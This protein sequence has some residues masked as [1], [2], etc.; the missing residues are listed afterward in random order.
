MNTSDIEKLNDIMKSDLSLDYFGKIIQNGSLCVNRY[1]LNSLKYENGIPILDIMKESLMRKALPFFIMEYFKVDDTNIEPFM[2]QYSDASFKF[3]HCEKVSEKIIKLDVD[4]DHYKDVII[5]YPEKI[6]KEIVRSYVQNSECV[7]SKLEDFNYWRYFKK[8]IRGVSE[9]DQ[10]RMK[11][12]T[13]PKIFFATN[14]SY[15]NVYEN[16]NV[17]KKYYNSKYISGMHNRYFTI[18]CQHPIKKHKTYFYKE[19][20]KEGDI[21]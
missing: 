6:G 11:Y 10:W 15:E 2:H 8:I 1:Y 9:R 3:E 17:I 5:R 4:K 19:I 14:T 20:E 16:R 21:Y 7:E 12:K 13:F 18:Y